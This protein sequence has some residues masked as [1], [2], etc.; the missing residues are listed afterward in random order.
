MRR[1]VV[2]AFLAMILSA[3]SEPLEFADWTIPVAAETQI[4][5]YPAVSVEDRTDR[6]ELVE[7]LVIGHKDGDPNYRFFAP[8]EMAVD[9]AERIY[10]VDTGNTRVQVFDAE[11]NYVMTLG[12]R[13]QGPGELSLPSGVAVVGDRVVVYDLQ[14]RRF[15]VWGTDGRH[16]GDYRPSRGRPSETMVGISSEALAT[17][18]DTAS[19]EGSRALVAGL[20]AEGSEMARYLDIPYPSAPRLGERVSLA[21]IVAFPSFAAS[22]TGSVYVAD[23]REYQVHAF[24]ASGGS[25]WALRAAA[26]RQPVDATVRQHVVELMRNVVPGLDPAGTEWPPMLPA[27]DRLAVDGHGR[28]Y[29]FPYHWQSRGWGSYGPM[30]PG[31]HSSP[32]D[33]YLPSGQRVFTGMMPSWSWAAAHGDYLYGFVPDETGEQ[34]VVRYRIVTPF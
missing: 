30:M 26:A 29:V 23:R 14:N 4:V 27:I 12:K 17:R 28:L 24:D 18:V 13:G 32:V 1:A 7:D 33:V 10:V 2:L 19:E 6:V 3:C 20:S 25:R 8:G 15:T 22:S 11:G 21:F 9:E 34:Q 31:T 16:F 5:E